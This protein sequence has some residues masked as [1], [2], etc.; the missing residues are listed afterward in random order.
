MASQLKKACGI[1][2]GSPLSSLRYPAEA[3]PK[4]YNNP[5]Y[6]SSGKRKQV[7]PASSPRKPAVKKT[8]STVVAVREGLRSRDT[9]KKPIRYR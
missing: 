9:L 6:S 8:A 5:M 2:S 3:V 7:S 4:F 1:K